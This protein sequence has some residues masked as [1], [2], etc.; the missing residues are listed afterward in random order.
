VKQEEEAEIKALFDRTIQLRKKDEQVRELA[1]TYL[2]ETL[3]RLHRA[4]E[5]QPYTGLKPAGTK[6]DEGIE[7]ADHALHHGSVDPLI[8]E[9][10]EQV[11]TGVR[12]RFEKAMQAEKNANASVEAGREY[13]EAYA[14]FLHYVE[15]IHQVASSGHS[16]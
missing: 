1:D 13:V 7:A 6:V 15:R 9:L 16:H 8:R 11:A 2:F 3:V 4:G 10:T 14:S 5:G 12:H